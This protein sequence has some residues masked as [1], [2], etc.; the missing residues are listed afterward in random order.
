MNDDEIRISIGE[1]ISVSGLDQRETEYT[2]EIENP[3]TYSLQVSKAVQDV[4]FYISEQM[5]FGDHM[6][7]GKTKTEWFG[8]SQNRLASGN[9]DAKNEE[10]TVNLDKGIYYVT[11]FVYKKDE[12]KIIEPFSFIIFKKEE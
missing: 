8:K 11:F 3:G 12:K 10:L 1:T 7:K 2:F 4:D 9:T 5:E 6:K